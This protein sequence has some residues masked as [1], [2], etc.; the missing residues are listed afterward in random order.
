M[1][2]AKGPIT[3]LAMDVVR[4]PA[5]SAVWMLSRCHGHDHAGISKTFCLNVVES[6]WESANMKESHLILTKRLL[7]FNHWICYLSYLQSQVCLIFETIP[8]HCQDH[9]GVEWGKRNG[10]IMK[11]PNSIS[12]PGPK[13]GKQ[14]ETPNRDVT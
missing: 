12:T 4:T 5:T 14:I 7:R 1:G 6:T 3:A 13:S 8:D 10:D 9:L 2:A 11:H